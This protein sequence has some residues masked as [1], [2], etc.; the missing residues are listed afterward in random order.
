MRMSG[1]IWNF[2]K[3]IM[4]LFFFFQYEQL[5]QLKAAFEKKMQRQHELSEV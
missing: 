5:T 2:F 1:N 3:V 4:F